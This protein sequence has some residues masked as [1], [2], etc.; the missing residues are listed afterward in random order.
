VP[1]T[2]A[3][4]ASL[5]VVLMAADLSHYA[6]WRRRLLA[7]VG[8]VGTSVI[9]AGVILRMQLA[10]QISA[11]LAHRPWAHG[12]VFGP[13]DYHGNAGSFI[14][15]VIP[16]MALSVALGQTRD[17]RVMW[18]GAL[19]L[20][21]VA[22]F[23]NTS[24]T[25]LLIA[26]IILPVIVCLIII[27][28]VRIR[29]RHPRVARHGI[30]YVGIIVAGSLVIIALLVYG[31]SRAAER[32]QSLPEEL[33]FPWNP[34]Y[35]QGR[36]GW[37]MARE[38]PIFGAGVGSYKLLVQ[39]SSI[40]GH[41]FAPRYRPGK[42]FNVLS[43]L[44]DDYLQTLVEWG[45]VGLAA[46]AILVGGAFLTLGSLLLKW[47]V[48]SPQLI[49]TSLAV[50]AALAGVYTHAVVDC[51]LQIPALQLYVALYLGLAWGSRNWK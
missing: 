27:A 13:I 42:P 12:D 32:L 48:I 33:S 7:T 29:D 43:H 11:Y 28:R 16:A 18:L 15:L 19:S 26:L 5:L 49:A 23:V 35:M 17:R 20:C 44:H 24:R 14:N 38:R 9:V 47:R 50:A 8:L 34:R 10:P 51:P 45:W 30:A 40:R 25:A 46:W 22:Q 2:A 37:E 21:Y 31:G 39:H 3:V 1:F 36:A 6:V 4:S 41:Y